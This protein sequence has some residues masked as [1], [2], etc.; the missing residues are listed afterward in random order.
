MRFGCTFLLKALIISFDFVRH[1]SVFINSANVLLQVAFVQRLVCCDLTVKKVSHFQVN[2][3][4]VKFADL[5][6]CTLNLPSCNAFI[7]QINFQAVFH[8]DCAY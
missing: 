3:Y 8:Y 2:V 7:F 1:F 4:G 6:V 5:A